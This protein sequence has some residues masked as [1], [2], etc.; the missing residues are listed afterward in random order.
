[1]Q[2]VLTIVTPEVSLDGK[3][4]RILPGGPDGAAPLPVV[5]ASSSAGIQ[6]LRST[7]TGSWISELLPESASDVATAGDCPSEVG[8]ASAD[9]PC[10]GMTTCTQHLSGVATGFDSARTQSGATFVAWVAYSSEATY[11]LWNDHRGGELPLSYCTRAE[12]SGTGTAELVLAR[13]T[14]SEPV[15]T[16]FRFDLSSGVTDL[17]RELAMAARGD[18]LIVT[19]TLDGDLATTLTSLEIDS[20]LLP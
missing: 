5:L 14:D 15:L 9:E 17:N 3:L 12:T 19:A 7:D 11:E 4:L 20:T 10:A 6:V 18:T 1:V 13:L 16:R 8:S 2:D